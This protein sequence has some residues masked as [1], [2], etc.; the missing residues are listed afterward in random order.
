LI[1]TSLTLTSVNLAGV[2][3]VHELLHDGAI[4]SAGCGVD[5]LHE[6]EAVG[7]DIAVGKDGVWRQVLEEG[8]RHG[9]KGWAV[10]AGPIEHRGE[11]IY[12]SRIES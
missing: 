1:R 3:A 8:N 4:S 12:Q 5:D 2:F 9:R 7:M 11:S 10:S 6:N